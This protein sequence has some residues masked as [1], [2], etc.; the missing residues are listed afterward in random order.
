M[1]GLSSSGCA[2]DACNAA[3]DCGGSARVGSSLRLGAITTPKSWSLAGA[4]LKLSSR[5]S[6]PTEAKTATYRRAELDGFI[7]DEPF[8]RDLLDLDTVAAGARRLAAVAGA[9]AGGFSMR[10]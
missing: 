8:G 9:L 1:A 7:D 10:S 3:R 5:A 2:V 6:P 4:V